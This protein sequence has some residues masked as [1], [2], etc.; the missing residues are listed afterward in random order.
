MKERSKNIL[1]KL[2][3]V[4]VFLA[5]NLFFSALLVVLFVGILANLLFYKYYL[6]PKTK[7]ESR[8]E[9]LVI[10]D[11]SYN[12]FLKTWEEQNNRIQKFEPKKYIN[13]FKAR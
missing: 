6:N 8:Q 12:D 9:Q 2:D 1:N 10:N 13:I 5:E 3:R 7:L 11:K 4:C